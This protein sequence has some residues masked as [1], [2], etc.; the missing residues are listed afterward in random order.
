MHPRIL[1]SLAVFEAACAGRPVPA[2]TA[3]AP[4]QT[5]G[6]SAPSDDPTRSLT[7]A[8][9]ESLGRWMSDVCEGRPNERSARVEGWCNDV[10]RGV[11][12]GSW[13]SRECMKNITFID[14]VCFR[15]T[16]RVHDMME[17]DRSVH[18]P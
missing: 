12:D 2:E 17:C 9:C 8:E 5:A 4:S 1:V 11:S 10:V 6:A 13:V 14:S 15:G 3:P 18:R 16:T 7:R